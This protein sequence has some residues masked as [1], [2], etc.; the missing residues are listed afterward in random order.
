MADH[1]HQQ[2]KEIFLEARQLSAEKRAAFVKEAAKGDEMLEDEVLQLLA[3]DRD[4]TILNRDKKNL[5]EA[6]IDPLGLTEIKAR[7]K[8]SRFSNICFSTRGRTG[9]AYFIFAIVLGCCWLLCSSANTSQVG[10]DSWRGNRCH[11]AI[12]H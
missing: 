11:I 1:Q 6:I 4:E 2:A 3:N 5:P 12:E 9:L 10:L 7:S 8:P